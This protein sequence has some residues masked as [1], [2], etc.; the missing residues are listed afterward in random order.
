MKRNYNSMVAS[1]YAVYC[2]YFNYNVRRWQAEADSVTPSGSLGV[3]E[4]L[5]LDKLNVQQSNA[6]SQWRNHIL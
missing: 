6:I 5:S 1:F 4:C 3:N 2:G